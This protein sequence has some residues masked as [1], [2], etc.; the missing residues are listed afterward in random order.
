MAKYSSRPRGEEKRPWKIHPIWRGFGCVW[1]IL[2]P[3]MAFAGAKLIVRSGILPMTG[4]VAGSVQLPYINYPF[5][6]FP[7][8]LNMLI[9]WLPQP[10]LLYMDLLVFFA[11]IFLGIGVMSVVYS[12]LYRLMGPPRT[13][14]DDPRIVNVKPTKRRW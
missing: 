9:N 3:I 6:S 2:L 12:F 14:F 7:I 4:A 13:I 8:D 1:L 10:P 5:M 11:L